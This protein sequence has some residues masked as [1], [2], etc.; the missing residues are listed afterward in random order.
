MVPE[1]KKKKK[2]K[3]MATTK[4]YVK[5]QDFWQKMIKAP[6]NLTTQTTCYGVYSQFIKIQVINCLRDPGVLNSC[7]HTV[8]EQNAGFTMA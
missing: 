3:N 2:E 6:S 7:M 5:I 4:L 8:P 1:I